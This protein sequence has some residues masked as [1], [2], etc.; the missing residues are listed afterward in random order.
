[1]SKPS[2]SRTVIDRLSSDV[3][4][5]LLL[6][7]A[8]VIALVWANSPF[9][10]SYETLWQTHGAISIG[11]F[12][13]DLSLHHWVNDGLMILFFFLIGLEVR[14][15]LTIGSL[16]DRRRAVVPL[17]AGL[18]GVVVPALI[19]LAI[20]GGEA[21]D[22]WGVVVG[23][24]TA[25]LLGVLALVGPRMSNQLRI[26][27][28]TLTVVDDFLAV[29]I[30]GAVYS[31]NVQLL[32]LGIA[33]LCVGALFLLGR[34]SEWR[35]GPYV[36]VI[37]ILWV[38]TLKSGVHPS[39]AGMIAGLLVPASEPAREDVLAAK[40]LF[41]DYWQSPRADA[42]RNVRLGLAKSIAVN[43]RL[44]DILR[45][46][47]A[48][49]VVP[50][51][52]L[53]NAGVDLGG[54]AFGDA[55]GSTVTWGVIAGLVLGKFIGIGLAAWLAVRAG[56][57][58]L[59]DGVG[60]GSIAGGAAL[61]GIGFTMSLLIVSLA[62]TG[63]QAR[64]ATIGVLIAMVLATLLGWATFELARVRWGET[65]ADLPTE[66]SLAVDPE[67]DHAIGGEHARH[68][69]VE[70]YDF[71]CPFCA[72]MTGMGQDLKA[73][74]GD[75]IRFVIRHLPVSERHQR[76]FAAAVAAEAAGRQGK[77]WE[78]HHLLFEHQ[79]ELNTDDLFG[80]A[81]EIDLDLDRF[82]ADLGDPEL[83]AHV[84]QD[85]DSAIASGATGTPTF[86]L[87]GVRHTG[88]QDARTIIAALEARSTVHPRR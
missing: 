32:P 85:H 11:D 78:M 38:A 74:F 24:D 46:P 27:L 16:T 6:V 40:T 20:A 81:R 43:E 49:I 58:R 56:L 57:G 67:R 51:F 9:A 48:L 53:A 76:A 14:E 26:F 71:E 82:A 41:R 7:A 66:L 80:Y 35:S 28:L 8:T 37:V 30:I 75:D 45:T 59:P 88:P 62:L 55:L 2:F 1:M 87:D 18:A 64:D 84:Q 17:I 61:S 50:L 54:G 44:L 22:G 63:Q 33:V 12:S 65:S 83:A 47:V 31:D 72:K 73:H 3:G 52:A 39:I 70:Y 25:F 5:A 79:E 19:Y 4:A 21:L 10:H 23:T 86:F 13:I 68:T 36:F 34:S 60:P 29:S 69:V 77:F 15:E 42:A